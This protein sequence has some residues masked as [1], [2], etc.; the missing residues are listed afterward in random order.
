MNVSPQTMKGNV[1]RVTQ[2]VGVFLDAG[3][4]IQSCFDWQS[5]SRT[6]VAF[7]VRLPSLKLIR[8]VK[9]GIQIGSDWPQLGQILDFLKSVYIL[10]HRAKMYQKLI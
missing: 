2:L 3:R 8:N 4:F 7:V 6:I 1:A 5:P 9:F 10:A